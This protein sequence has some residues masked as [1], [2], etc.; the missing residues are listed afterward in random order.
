MK[1]WLYGVLSSVLEQIAANLIGTAMLAAW[2]LAS[3]LAGGCISLLAPESS[4][5]ALMIAAA[6]V[7]AVPFMALLRY[8]GKAPP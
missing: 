4:V 1:S 8:L 6:L 7:L 3:G 5:V 2:L